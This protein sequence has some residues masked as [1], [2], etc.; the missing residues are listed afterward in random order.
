MREGIGTG[1]LDLAERKQSLSL[2]VYHNVKFIQWVTENVFKPTEQIKEVYLHNLSRTSNSLDLEEGCRTT[3][4]S[5]EVLFHPFSWFADMH[6]LGCVGC[7]PIIAE[8]CL[9]GKGTC[10]SQ[11]CSLEASSP[12]SENHYLLQCHRN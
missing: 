8:Q 4:H 9:P 2:G 6:S 10:F 1:T 5:L 11:V 3:G 7:P 12:F